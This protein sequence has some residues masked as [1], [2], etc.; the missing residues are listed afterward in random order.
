MCSVD[1]RR[2][3][4][5]GF[6]RYTTTSPYT[7]AATI[8]YISLDH[9]PPMQGVHMQ[10]LLPRRQDRAHVNSQ[11]S[12]APSRQALMSERANM[13]PNVS[14]T[15][16]APGLPEF[17]TTHGGIR[18]RILLLHALTLAR[19]RHGRGKHRVRRRPARHPVHH[20]VHVS[21]ISIVVVRDDFYVVQALRGTVG[22]DVPLLWTLSKRSAAAQGV[23]W[24][25][26]VSLEV[27]ECERNS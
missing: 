17:C 3:L 21:A 19:L 4:W 13:R 5:R 1:P 10:S 27:C 15:F 11:K 20:I 7:T 2:A 6:E 23:R 16:R 25:A 24:C 14:L 18:W 8:S 26:L 22:P 9:W 12:I